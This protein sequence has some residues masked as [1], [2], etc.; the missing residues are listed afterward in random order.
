MIQKFKFVS[1]IFFEIYFFKWIFEYLRANKILFYIFPI[2]NFK[3]E[4]ENQTLKYY[5]ILWYTS[6]EEYLHTHK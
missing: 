6:L 4:V 5:K 3:R 2:E 1:K